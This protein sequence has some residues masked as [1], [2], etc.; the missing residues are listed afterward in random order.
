MRQNRRINSITSCN[1]LWFSRFLSE[2]PSWSPG[3]FIAFYVVFPA[4]VL[5]FPHFGVLR[6]AGKT[7]AQQ[8]KTQTPNC[9]RRDLRKYT[10]RKF[11]RR[12]TFRLAFFI[13][14]TYFHIVAHPSGS[15]SYSV[16]L[17]HLLLDFL[18]LPLDSLHLLVYFQRV[19]CVKAVR[20]SDMKLGRF[21]WS[22]SAQFEQLRKKRSLMMKQGK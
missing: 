19:P 5:C 1:G 4:F 20:I 22:A 14:V 13:L 11:S 3:Y 7:P 8:N 21:S 10:C 6:E 12:R 9:P 2:F 16:H 18:A 15:R 17:F